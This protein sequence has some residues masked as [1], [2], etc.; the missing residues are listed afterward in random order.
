MESASRFH[1]E[2]VMVRQGA[3]AVANG[4]I[5]MGAWA[6]ERLHDK[7]PV[8]LKLLKTMD[9]TR[10]LDQITGA[11]ATMSQGIGNSL[12]EQSPTANEISV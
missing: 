7:L 6:V 3:K 9:P 1:Q 10:G 5:D 4:M 12:L 11:A 2:N 8:V